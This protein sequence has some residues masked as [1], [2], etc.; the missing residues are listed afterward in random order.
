MKDCRLYLDACQ[1]DWQAPETG[2]TLGLQVEARL[3]LDF[4]GEFSFRGVF[5]Y[6]SEKNA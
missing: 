1:Q 2:R 5:F 3:K 4:F 6:C